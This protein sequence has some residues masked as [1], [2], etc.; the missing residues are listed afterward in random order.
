MQLSTYAYALSLYLFLAHLYL[1]ISRQQYPVH[2]L[3]FC[4]VVSCIKCCYLSQFCFAAMNNCIRIREN[5]LEFSSTV[6]PATSPY[7]MH[8]LRTTLPWY[9]GCRSTYGLTSAL[10]TAYCHCMKDIN[11]QLCTCS[12]TLLVNTSTT[13]VAD[14]SCRRHGR[15]AAV[16]KCSLK[17]LCTF[18]YLRFI[19]LLYI[20]WTVTS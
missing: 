3:S 17:R 7:H 8:R 15:W 14:V 13:V 2:R 12:T 1:V 20:D 18:R 9:L 5:T 10:L 4:N 19:I 11:T 16:R 6:L